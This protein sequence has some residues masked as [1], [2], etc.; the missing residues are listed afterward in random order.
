[1][2]DPMHWRAG[3]TRPPGDGR[4]SWP[5]PALATWLEVCRFSAQF[6]PGVGNVD[7]RGDGHGRALYEAAAE[8]KRLLIIAG[9]RHNDVPDVGGRAYFD[10][11]RE[12]CTIAPS[13]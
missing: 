7:G 2:P 4:G 6:L 11:L 5:P 10:A 8:P 12:F 13:P 3:A 9:A 1:M